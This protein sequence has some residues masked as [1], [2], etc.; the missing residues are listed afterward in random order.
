MKYSL[1][2][3]SVAVQKM[4]AQHKDA[5]RRGLVSAVIKLNQYIVLQLIPRNVPQPVDRG[6]YRAGWKFTQLSETSVYLYNSAPHASLVENGVKEVTIGPALI[7]ALAAWVKRKGIGS[8]IEQKV[9]K[10]E[11][12]LRVKKPN[13]AEARAIAWAIAMAAKKNGGFFNRGNGLKILE[14][15]MAIAPTVLSDSI[16]AEIKKGGLGAYSF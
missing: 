5:A 12:K 4:A 9:V 14:K 8:R 10:G 16:A 15:A 1:N 6:A 2:Q 7:D 11:V 3:A 13:K